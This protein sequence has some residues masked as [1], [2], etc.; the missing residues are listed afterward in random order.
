[1]ITL[2]NN[3]KSGSISYYVMLHSFNE[4]IKLHPSESG[5]VCEV[6]SSNIKQTTSGNQVLITPSGDTLKSTEP[7]ES[8]YPFSTKSEE[9]KPN[10]FSIQTSLTP[11]QVQTQGN[12]DDEG[13]REEASRVDDYQHYQDAFDS[14]ENLQKG[15]RPTTTQEKYKHRNDTNVNEDLNNNQGLEVNACY[16]QEGKNPEYCDPNYLQEIGPPL[17]VVQDSS[18]MY[19]NEQDLYTAIHQEMNKYSDEIREIEK[20]LEANIKPRSNPPVTQKSTHLPQMNNSSPVYY[21]AE[22]ESFAE[23]FMTPT[24]ALEMMQ[25]AAFAGSSQYPPSVH[26]S[27]YE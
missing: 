15:Y 26:L 8:E 9:K 19:Q 10:N 22:S 5:R 25:D 17:Q 16:I 18:L 27:T 14:P 11:E 23:E 6:R 20:I 13:Q 12:L 2:Q 7:K 4:T 21:E 24:C 1:M 3:E